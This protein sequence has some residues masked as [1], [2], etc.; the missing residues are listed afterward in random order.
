M[1]F[2]QTKKCQMYLEFPLMSL[3]LA[4]CLVI[5]RINILL[6]SCK[7]SGSSRSILSTSPDSEITKSR[8]NLESNELYKHKVEWYNTWINGPSAYRKVL[9]LSN[10]GITDWTNMAYSLLTG[11][12]TAFTSLFSILGFS[13]G[14]FSAGLSSKSKLD[15]KYDSKESHY[16]NVLSNDFP[17]LNHLLETWL[18]TFLTLLF[19]K[20][21]NSLSFFFSFALLWRL[22]YMSIT[23][24]Q[25]LQKVLWL[26][27][28][29]TNVL[30]EKGNQRQN[31]FD[32]LAHFVFS[33]VDCYVV[34]L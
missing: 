25:H 13:S 8:V 24:F 32:N 9:E 10:I 31:S 3:S 34:K 12:L 7:T 18:I 33:E 23:K 28:Q 21:M 4:Y 11:C 19:L 6:Q 17:R 1:P 27:F 2:R 26:P 15:R 20:F 30:S 14:W 16:I 5:A 29:H 22:W